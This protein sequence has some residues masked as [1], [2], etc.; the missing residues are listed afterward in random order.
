VIFQEANTYF[1]LPYSSQSRIPV[2][3]QDCRTTLEIHHIY[4]GGSCGYPEH[5]IAVF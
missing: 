2:I 3:S 1:N 4:R 5:I